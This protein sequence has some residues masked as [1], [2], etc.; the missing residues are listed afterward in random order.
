MR[1]VLGR[2]RFVASCL[3]LA[4]AF[5]A[6]LIAVGVGAPAAPAKGSVTS[7]TEFIYLDDARRFV[8]VLRDPETGCEYFLVKGGRKGGLTPRLGR[9]GEPMCGEQ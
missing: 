8:T 3:V 4:I 7:G 2:S 6:V 5:C 9:D 1:F